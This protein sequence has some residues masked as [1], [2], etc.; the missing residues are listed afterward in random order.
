[1]TKLQLHGSAPPTVESLL[2]HDVDFR[3]AVTPGKHD[4]APCL[5]Q[6]DDAA[7]AASAPRDLKSRNQSRMRT[8]SPPLYGNRQLLQLAKKNFATG[9]FAGAYLAT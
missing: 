4:D 7:A 1:M 6:R 2:A 8:S 9:T 3:V 5:A